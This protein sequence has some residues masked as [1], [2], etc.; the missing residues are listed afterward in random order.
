MSNQVR[1]LLVGE[2]L[3][4]IGK[5]RELLCS[6]GTDTFFLES[7]KNYDE[8]LSVPEKDL[9]NILLLKIESSSRSAEG[10]IK[11]WLGKFPGKPLIV[12]SRNHETE[13]GNTCIASGAQDFLVL[14][15]LDSLSLRQAICKAIE[16]KKFQ[17][18]FEESLKIQCELSEEFSKANDLKDLLIDVITHDLKNAAGGIYSFASL[19]AEGVQDAEMVEYIRLLSKRLVD[20]IDNASILSK[21][22]SG[23]EIEKENIN[24]GQVIREVVEEFSHSFKTVG[25]EVEIKCTDPLLIRA[26]HIISQVVRNYLNNAIKYAASGRKIVIEANPSGIHALMKIAD[27]GETIPAEQRE[28][29]FLRKIQLENGKNRGSGFGLAIVKRIAKAHDAKVWVEPNEPSGNRFCMLIEK[30]G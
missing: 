8:F 30:I 23:E 4:D 11:D 18:T 3:G 9:F 13:Y 28:N 15:E 16:R 1:I 25:L 14:P 7:V 5:L 17:N 26:N 12:L 29:I 6:P 20:T 10:E 22:T 2:E 21:V 19:M 27:F 24:L